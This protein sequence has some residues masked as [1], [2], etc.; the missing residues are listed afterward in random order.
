MSYF[1]NIS[2]TNLTV[3]TPAKD[4]PLGDITCLEQTPCHGFRLDG[5]RIAQGTKSPQALSCTNLAPD[6]IVVNSDDA[7]TERCGGGG[8][9]GGGD[10]DGSN[11]P[12]I[13]LA[14]C[15]ASDPAQHWQF[16]GHDIRSLAPALAKNTTCLDMKK[17]E[18]YPV[19][20]YP[21]HA[22]NRAALGQA[23]LGDDQWWGFSGNTS[24]SIHMLGTKGN[25]C[26]DADAPAERQ[27]LSQKSLSDDGQGGSPHIFA[28]ECETSKASQ[29]WALDQGTG[30]LRNG[31]SDTNKCLDVLPAAS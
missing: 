29:L 7:I 26:L 23:I 4:F 21:C 31:G 22:G 13:G 8:G 16:N 11:C 9:G 20:L 27:G 5:I 14:A 10:C 30:L 3:S 6:A 24:G 25:L 18:P 15:N 17:E 19:S 1:S 12:P 2:F 28:A